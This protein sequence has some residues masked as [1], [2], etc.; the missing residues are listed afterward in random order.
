[1]IQPPERFTNSELVWKLIKWNNKA[2][3]YQEE[4]DGMLIN[5]FEVHKFRIWKEGMIR[6]K[7]YPERYRI[8]SNEEFGR[9]GWSFNR[10]EE[11]EK[12]FEALT[13][14]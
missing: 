3:L 11:A 13:N 14:G 5:N 8:P 2:V 9:Y 6:G 4:R 10:L 7:L 1:M 12:D